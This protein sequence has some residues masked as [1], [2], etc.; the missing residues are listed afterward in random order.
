MAV[1]Y[2]AQ[3]L[4]ANS[5]YQVLIGKRTATTLFF[6]FSNRITS[7][8]GLYPKLTKEEWAQ[9]LKEAA[10]YP[11]LTTIYRYHAQPSFIQMV[12]EEIL[13]LRDGLIISSSRQIYRQTLQLMMQVV[14]YANVHVRSYIPFVQDIHAQFLVKIWVNHVKNVFQYGLADVAKLIQDQL[15][16]DLSRYPD[17]AAMIFLQQFEGANVPAVTLDQIAEIHEASKREILIVQ[18]AITDDLWA[19]W[20]KGKNATPGQ[21][22]L[23]DF[24]NVVDTF[25][26]KWNDST[27][28]TAI[29][30]KGATIS[31]AEMANR[32]HL[33]PSTIT[34]HFI[35]IAFSQ[36]ELLVNRVKA[37]LQLDDVGVLL[38][39]EPDATFDAFQARFGDQD[40]W[41]YRYWKIIYQKG[42]DGLWD[43]RKN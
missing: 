25:F 22:L 13:P 19:Q 6:A 11:S 40:Y 3:E 38:D 36:P 39:H 34:E 10:N 24:V 42:P 37:A 17:Q 29:M 2:K 27:N 9:Y 1:A 28:K 18:Q 14:S 5:V 31:V 30:L 41:L 23:T 33:K 35:E 43:G 20:L 7:L 12:I 32:R 26:K 8:I 4:P 16:T 15:L 21:V